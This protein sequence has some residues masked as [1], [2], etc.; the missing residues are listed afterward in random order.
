M[1]YS[2]AFVA[3]VALVGCGGGSNPPAPI[4]GVAGDT[5]VAAGP[6]VTA[7]VV[8]TAFNFSSGVPGLGT[9]AATSVAFTS[10]AASPAFEIS[11]GGFK[12][13]G[14]TTF[15]SCIFKVGNSTFPAGHALANG[16]TVTV[17]PCN[18]NIN[19]TGAT[20][21]G[22]ATSRS[23]ALLLGAAA[24]AGATVTVAVNAGG[25]IVLNGATV[26]TVTLTPVTGSGSGG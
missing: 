16:Q 13:E 26:A 14:T 24:S 25:Q 19:T 17:N 21:N 12:A 23:V 8:N 4:Y 18:I 2:L 15:G 20:A 9:T 1:K 7:A 6:V 10:T 3:C 22:Q 11:S 5:V